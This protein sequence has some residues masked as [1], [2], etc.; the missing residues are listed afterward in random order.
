MSAF[1][2]CE[3]DM[4]MLLSV[5]RTLGGSNVSNFAAERP[6]RM[7]YETKPRKVAEAPK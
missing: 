7:Y 6:I 3:N 2:Y 1:E 4:P 5:S